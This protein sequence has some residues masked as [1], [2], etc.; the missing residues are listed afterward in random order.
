M[1]GRLRATIVRHPPRSPRPVRQSIVAL[2]A[3]LGGEKSLDGSA[4]LPEK[5][6]VTADV[7]FSALPTLAVVATLRGWSNDHLQRCGLA[8]KGTG[9][10]PWAV[11]GSPA[12]PG[13]SAQ[14]YSAPEEQSDP[15]HTNSRDKR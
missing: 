13:R 10:P 14:P 9:E 11:M 7:C 8:A 2:T 5:R 4:T 3:S 15:S 1:I 12:F 6:Q